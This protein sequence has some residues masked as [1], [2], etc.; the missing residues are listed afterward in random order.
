MLMA[1]KWLEHE[2]EYDVDMQS[3]R[4]EKPTFPPQLSATAEYYR[5]K[6]CGALVG[7]AVL[8]GFLGDER[9][10]GILRPALDWLVNSPR[11]EGR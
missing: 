9:S 4:C 10:G 3:H 7:D 2:W 8:K 1:A 5:C 6:G 11:T